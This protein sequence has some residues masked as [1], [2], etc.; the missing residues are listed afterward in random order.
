MS[1][2]LD[3]AIDNIVGSTPLG[4]SDSIED[5]IARARGAS[6]LTID[7]GVFELD[8][9]KLNAMMKAARSVGCQ[10]FKLTNVCGQTLIGS[11]VPGPVKIDVHGLMGNHSAAF[12]DSATINTY[13]T[14]FPNG[15]VCPGDAQVA[16]GNSANPVEI[17]V[18]GSVD[19]LFASYSPSGIFRVAG[20]GGNRCALRCG[21]GSSDHW[22]AIDYERLRSMSKDERIE[23]MLLKYQRRR[24]KINELG[25][26]KFLEEYKTLIERRSPPVIVFGRRTRDYFMEYAQ[27][28]VG[29]ILNLFEIDAPVGYYSCS[30]MTAGRAYIRGAFGEERLGER[31]VFDKLNMADHEF[32]RSVIDQ[33]HDRF[34]TRMPSSYQSRL[35]ALKEKID[36]DPLS[37]T[38]QFLK[39]VPTPVG[40]DS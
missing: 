10:H 2:D 20:Q 33:F 25:W 16:I 40:Q 14:Y 18:G 3:S 30:G 11:G 29:V 37:V 32:L 13:S 27:G 21:A 26:R 39:I 7:C 4:A 24:A 12:V 9:E 1:D 22:R 6:A 35:S 15:V 5:V 23:D 34:D 19:D 17:N 28:T 31:V 36:S 38:S 8:G